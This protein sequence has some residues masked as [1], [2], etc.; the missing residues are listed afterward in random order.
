MEREGKPSLGLFVCV[1]M[2]AGKDYG[3][4]MILISVLKIMSWIGL[5]YCSCK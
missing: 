1:I 5:V 2:M 4:W 3:K